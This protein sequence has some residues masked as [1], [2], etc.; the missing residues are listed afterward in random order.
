MSE[1]QNSQ[2]AGGEATPTIE[3]RLGSFDFDGQPPRR[4]TPAEN[5]EPGDE[6]DPT[7]LAA[8]DE[9]GE[10]EKPDE[11]NRKVRLRDGREIEIAELKKAYRPEWEKETKEFEERRK[12]F[13]AQ[14]QQV[15]QRFQSLTQQEQLLSQSL[16][17]AMIVLQN[18]LPKPPD[19]G[20]LETDPFAYQ[21]QKV[22][23]DDAMGE[24]HQL[25]QKHQQI[26]HVASQRAYQQFEQH[27]AKQ[28]EMLVAA[29]PEI[30][31]PVKAAKFWEE[32]K[33]YGASVGF[34]PQELGQIADWRVL[35]VLKDANA[36]R[37]FQ[38]RRAKLQEKEKAAAP[39]PPPTTQPARRVSSA[40]REAGV[41]RQQLGQLRKT[42]SVKD[43]EA[44]LS[45]FD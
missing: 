5:K 42:G 17:S 40:E 12:Q 43:A 36:W 45:K 3:D 4:E 2:P 16:E 29:M 34:T 30:K 37:Q 14:A 18:R 21:S 33:S 6:I 19:R 32:A 31:D 24:I 22:A 35:R 26:K 13:E 41:V 15:G 7:D 20:L 1:D 44:F 39:M 28:H 10:P 8:A 25:A 27:K 38:E 9:V 23:Y 11:D